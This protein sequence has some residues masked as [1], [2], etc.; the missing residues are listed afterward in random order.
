MP[1]PVRD[2]TTLLSD[3]V[4]DFSIDDLSDRAIYRSKRMILDS[5]GVGTIGSQTE[6][7]G[8]LRE[9][10]IETNG[11]NSKSMSLVWGTENLKMPSPM[12][13]YLNG[14]STHTMDFDDT[15]HPA[16][17]PSGP[18]L[19]AILALVDSLPRSYMVSLQDVLVAF[20]IGIQIQG[21]LLRCSNNA[22]NIPNR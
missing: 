22:K 7:A 5:I 18:V 8:K 12:A 6:I 14:C 10:A 20:N 9:F 15:W 21:A 2:L 11:I 1:V 13:A 19:P 17:H 16:T 3:H 4:A